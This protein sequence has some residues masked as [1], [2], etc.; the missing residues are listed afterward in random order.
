MYH[1]L[2]QALWI[3]QGKNEKGEEGQKRDRNHQSPRAYMLANKLY[4]MLLVSA[5]HSTKAGKKSSAM[6][7]VWGGGGWGGWVLPHR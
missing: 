7:A 4:R 2:F 5:M 1:E 3:Q 6:L